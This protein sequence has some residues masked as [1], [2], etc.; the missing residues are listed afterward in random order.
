MLEIHLLFSIEYRYS[1]SLNRYRIYYVN[2]YSYNNHRQIA[3]ALVFYSDDPG[4]YLVLGI[5]L[6]YRSSEGPGQ[7]SGGGK[8][9]LELIL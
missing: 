4:Q 2:N 5:S 9:S 8:G 6:S 7:E 3:G 1:F